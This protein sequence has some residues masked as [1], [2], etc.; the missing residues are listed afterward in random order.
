MYR[1][2]KNVHRVG[3][4]PR[5][6]RLHSYQLFVP[7]DRGLLDVNCNNTRHI[8][9]KHLSYVGRSSTVPCAGAVQ[10]RLEDP[11]NNGIL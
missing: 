5:Y 3:S 4:R 7:I 6:R 8:S 9:S 1:K 2:K 11:A 10:I